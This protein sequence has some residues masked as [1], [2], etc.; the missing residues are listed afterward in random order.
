MLLMIYTLMT[1]HS[2]HTNNH[3]LLNAYF[4]DTLIIMEGYYE[5]DDNFD[6]DVFC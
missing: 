2:S 3:N 5:R 4:C 1:T 6:R